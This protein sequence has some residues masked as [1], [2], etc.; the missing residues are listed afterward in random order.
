[1]ADE[2]DVFARGIR[3]AETGT[4][5]GSYQRVSGLVRGSNR[6]LGAYA[7]ASDDWSALASDAGMEGARWKDPKA[8]DLVAKRTFERLYD[9]YGDWRLVAVAWKAGEKIADAV[10]NDPTILE[11]KKLAPVKSYARQVMKHAG[12]NLKVTKPTFR[13]GTPIPVESFPSETDGLVPAGQDE[14]VAPQDAAEQ[15]LREMLVAMR[16]RERNLGTAPPEAAPAPVEEAV[17]AAPAPTPAPEVVAS[18]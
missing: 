10:A 6:L 8:Q 9:R 1:M 11:H 14:P 12:K 13:D 18:A 4:A 7:I 3:M 16:E 5:E 17:P 2:S 15:A